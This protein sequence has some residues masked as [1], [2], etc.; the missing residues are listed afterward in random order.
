MLLRPV[1][2]KQ[3]FH[4]RQ[5]RDSAH[6]AIRELLDR[7]FGKPTQYVAADNEPAFDELDLE[8]CRAGI[9]AQVQRTFPEYRL[10][11]AK[12]LKFIAGPDKLSSDAV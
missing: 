12:G 6:C 5:R 4:A 1:G 10:V 7:S 3:A 2:N 9:L 11:P 8:E